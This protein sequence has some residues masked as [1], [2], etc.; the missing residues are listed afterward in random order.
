MKSGWHCNFTLQTDFESGSAATDKVSA[1][2]F[3]QVHS[4]EEPSGHTIHLDN[5]VP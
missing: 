2:S 4:G 3:P 5:Q 1:A